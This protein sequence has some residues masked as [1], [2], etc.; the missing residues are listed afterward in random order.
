MKTITGKTGAWLSSYNVN[1][2]PSDV[3]NLFFAN[4]DMTTSGWV[5]VGDATITV[6]LLDAHDLLTGQLAMLD[7]AERRV[8]AEAQAKLNEIEGQRQRLLAIEYKP[9]QT[10]EG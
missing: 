1:A 9:C 8:K 3:N 5:R 4:S 10:T 7:E 2:D 6:V